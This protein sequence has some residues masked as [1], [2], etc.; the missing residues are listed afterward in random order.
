[1]RVPL[2]YKVTRAIFVTIEGHTVTK[3]QETRN[4]ENASSKS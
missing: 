3:K 4:Y 2:L 1:M